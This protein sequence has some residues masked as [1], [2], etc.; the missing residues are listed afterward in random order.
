V[1]GKAGLYLQPASKKAQFFDTK[2]GVSVS[3]NS[4]KRFGRYLKAYTFALPIK[5]RAAIS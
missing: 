1:N 2:S 4:E 3:K 5:K